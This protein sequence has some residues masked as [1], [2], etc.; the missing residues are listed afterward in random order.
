MSIIRIE[1]KE[2]EVRKYDEC[3]KRRVINKDD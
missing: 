3:T 1:S 2:R